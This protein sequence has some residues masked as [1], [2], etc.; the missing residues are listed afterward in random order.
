MQKQSAVADIDPE[1]YRIAGAESVL[2]PALLVYPQIVECNIRNTIRL[3]NG[4]PNRWRPHIKTAKLASVI[5]TLVRHGVTNFKCATTLELLTACRG[6]ALDVLVANQVW[7]ANA[8]RVREIAQQ[9]PR[10]R[11]SVLVDTPSAVESWAGSGVEVFI[12]VNPGMNRTGIEQE[13]VD[14]IVSVARTIQKAKVGFRGLHYYDG[15]LAKLQLPERTRAAHH[16]YDQLMDIVAILEKSNVSIGEI[17]TAGTPAFPCTISYPRFQSGTFVHRA[18]PGTVVY[19]DVLTLDQLLPEVG[20]RPAVLV[21]SRV[22]SRPTAGRVTC[23]AGH[24][25]LAV[26]CGIPNCEVLGQP[27]LQPLSPSEE[28]L[29]LDVPPGVAEPR[30]GDLLYLIPCHVCPT[31]NNFD[32]ALIVSEGKIVDV[33][34]V[35]ARGRE[36]P[37]SALA[38]ESSNASAYPRSEGR[39]E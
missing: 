7:G 28:H 16:G 15:H 39:G 6:G 27:L 37:L 1:A 5:Q 24:K 33:E 30:I 3:L 29:P 25:A 14:E 4:D 18:S 12:D 38:G 26:D 20:Y 31:V 21:L 19:M 17:I 23:D 32:D 8:D 10:V 36:R 13:G 22:I 11:I 34:R 2:T 35:T 9:F